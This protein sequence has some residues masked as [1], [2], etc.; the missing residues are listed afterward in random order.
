MDSLRK[1]LAYAVRALR[2]SPTFALT[3]ILTLA[4]GIGV[5][6]AI[7]SV[8][9]AVLLRPL[10]YNDADRLVLV[11]G[12]MRARDVTDFPFPPGDYQDLKNEASLFEDFA[13]LTPG[14]VPLGADDGGEPEQ[15]SATGVTPNLLTLLG[16]RIAVGR[17]FVP[18]D[19]QPQQPPPQ[20]G[21]AGGA[22]A[23]D[24]PPPPP[25]PVVVILNHDFWQRRYG[26]DPKIVGQTI[27]LGGGRALVAGVLAPGFE[28]LFPPG[29]G[30]DPVPDMFAAMR[31]NYETASRLNVFLRVVGKLKP[32]VP[33]SA[34]QDQV[35]RVSAEL[36]ERF[37]IKKTADVHFRLEPMHEDLVADV[38]PAIVALLGAVGFVLLIACANVA[39]LLLVRAASREREL[40]VRAALG[41]S[42][43]RL[44]R[45]MLAES[46]VL[47][48]G[49][50]LL[51]L[52][53]A[54]GGIKLL[55]ALAPANLPRL[56]LV[57]ID[58]LVLG[59]TILVALIAAA[60]F[61]VL[62]SVRASRPDLAEVL[63]STGRTPGL[64][65]GKLLRSGVVM[66]EVALSFVLLVGGGLMVRS[67]VALQNADPGYDATGVLTFQVSPIEPQSEARA[68][69]IRQL[70]ERLL[71]LPGVTAV[72]AA[73]PFPLDGRTA[74]LRW[75]T[76]EAAADPARFEQANVHIVLPGYFAAMHTR[77]LDG[78]AFTEADNRPDAT[79]IIIDD[80]LAAKAFP[81]E[82]AV[83]KRLF[84]R[85][86]SQEP[87]WLDVIGVVAHQRH[88]S[89]VAPG[90]EAVFVADGFMGFGATDR[91]AVRTTGD[92]TRLAPAVR[93]VV[94]ELDPRLP[95][96][97]VQPM[98][99]LVDRAMGPT[100]FALVLIGIFAAI[101]AVLAGVGLYGVLATAVRQRTA[102]I[103]VRMA[104]GSPTRDIFRLIIGEGLKLS[105]AGLAVGLVAAFALT[106]VM[107]SLLVG[108][109]ATDPVTFAA[110]VGLFLA[111]AV[112]A[113]WIPAR[114]AAA[115]D[116]TRALRGE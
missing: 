30:I 70:H 116:P 23:A 93:R 92:P 13:A 46:L 95:V 88:E 61:G 52:G 90:D 11:W 9:N 106:R 19:A 27:D 8:A 18:E 63:R 84:V 68:A 81:N 109:G 71:A 26:G 100:R 55:V 58:P 91:W 33:L 76:A 12:D 20:A 51:G 10:P 65:G 35:E 111:I 69:F 5:S 60:L 38:R 105:L 108:V 21:G 72:T 34:A 112:L 45:Q 110:M 57:R 14:R 16:A 39:N 79:G 43:W 40:A 113:C 101:A 80:L 28:I 17:N 47:A 99:V 24:A 75:G 82:R 107:R 32:G 50:A 74:N 114:R 15:V 78:R 36:R 102:E 49:A 66:A 98:Q 67:F 29:T 86:R 89:L 42:P 1:D 3:A 48:G 104:F 59:F 37:P 64:Q 77:L 22:P 97:E 53:L 96:A 31:I 94:N 85:V 56:D 115:M 41:S 2:N 6:T 62:P 4:L 54:Y 25:L 7:F 87:E 103:G 44:V 83:G 73:N